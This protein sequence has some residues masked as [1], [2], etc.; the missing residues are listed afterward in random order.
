MSIS[1]YK[2]VCIYVYL[3][4]HT[5]VGRNKLSI[6]FDSCLENMDVLASFFIVFFF[7]PSYPI[8]ML[9]KNSSLNEKNF[10]IK[11]ADEKCI[12]VCVFYRGGETSIPTE[13]LPFELFYC[14][15]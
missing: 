5:Y 14:H 15:I 1:Q 6:Y 4:V 3:E 11:N 9:N 7:L 10:T 13:V 2:H 12:P 8:S